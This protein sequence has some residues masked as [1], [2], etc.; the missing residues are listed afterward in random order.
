MVQ[1]NLFEKG[2][3]STERGYSVTVGR[4]NSGSRRSGFKIPALLL[5]FYIILDKLLNFSRL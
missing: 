4:M 2:Q 3:G 5:T 1:T